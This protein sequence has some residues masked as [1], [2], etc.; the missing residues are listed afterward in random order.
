M[1]MLKRL[2]K[3]GGVT[4][5][6]LFRILIVAAGLY[7]LFMIRSVLGI[8]FVSLIFASAISPLVDWLNRKR[9]PRPLGILFI[10]LALFAVLSTAFGLVI[11]PMASQI[12]QIARDFPNYY[13]RM[14]TSFSNFRAEQNL[15][16][17]FLASQRAIESFQDTLTKIT[18]GIPSLISTVFGGISFF[19]L[20]LVLT[21]YMTVERDG[22]KRFF[23]FITPVPYREYVIDAV[24]R[25]QRK[26]GMWLR[27]QL[28]LMLVVGVLTFI[29][30]TL[31]GVNFAVVLAVVAGITEIIPYAG[32]I[33]GAIPAVFLAFTQSP[34]LGFLVLILYFVVQQLENHLIVPKVMQRAVGLHPIIVISVILIGAKLGGVVGAIL[35]VPAATAGFI[36]LEDFSH[37]WFKNYEQELGI[38]TT[39]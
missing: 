33:I 37:G 5:A 4:Y 24:Q 12:G 6:S 28:V 25:I 20:V 9:I 39:K 7:F 30:L 13:E 32:P 15:E 10:Y 17:S 1:R 19:V 2:S 16:Q 38:D 35:A 27:G 21:F 34:T 36:L 8:L 26:L 29:G 3:A 22:L 11:P 31:L 18:Q 23:V 14:I